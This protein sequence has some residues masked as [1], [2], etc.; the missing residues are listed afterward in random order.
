LWATLLVRR[1]CRACLLTVAWQEGMH[2]LTILVC[3]VFV[4]AF[5]RREGLEL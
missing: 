2:A 1:S 3:H 4:V 5:S